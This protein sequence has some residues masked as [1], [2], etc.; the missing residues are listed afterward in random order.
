MA[1]GPLLQSSSRRTT[2][3]N[4]TLSGRVL[5]IGCGKGGDIQKWR[6]A[7]IKEYV[8]LDLA[9]VSVNQARERWQNWNGNKSDRF[10]ATFAQL[11]CYTHYLSESEELGPQVLSQPFDVV[12]MQFCMHYAFE[13]E[14]KVRVMLD[15]VTK[16]LRPG[17]RFIGTI[18]NSDVLLS[19]LDE[20]RKSNP[21]ALSF[22]NDVYN[23]RF[24]SYE[25]PLYGHRYVFFLADAVEDVPEYVVYWREFVKLAGQFGLKLVYKRE[26][27][28]IYVDDAEDPEFKGL[29]RRMGVVD[30]SNESAMDHAQ[31][32]AANVY[33]AFA[34]EKI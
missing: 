30:E 13:T 3:R 2:S 32:D 6:N 27:H 1:H 26:F 5:D 23:V 20:A 4:T 21:D 28:D 19:S 8:G 24:D 34:F 18:P 25:G 17:G 7:G 15:N 22:G 29:L 11:D 16:Y 14:K 31:W 10:D 12:T 33:L 9:I